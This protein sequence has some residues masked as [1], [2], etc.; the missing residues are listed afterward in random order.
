MWREDRC[1]NRTIT[2]NIHTHTHKNENSPRGCYFFF[3]CGHFM[4]ELW[5]DK[6]KVLFSAW[7]AK[8]MLMLLWQMFFKIHLSRL[9]VLT[10]LTDHRCSGLLPVSNDWIIA[11]LSLWWKWSFSKSLWCD[12][13]KRLQI[14]GLG[15]C[16]NQKK[17]RGGWREMQRDLAISC[18]KAQLLIADKYGTSIKFNCLRFATMSVNRMGKNI[19]IKKPE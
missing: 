14:S 11:S 6:K 10:P 5:P 12:Q 13:I 7:L 16:T 15:A 2:L 8:R 19:V 17:H 9:I 3:F 1:F 4:Q 18:A